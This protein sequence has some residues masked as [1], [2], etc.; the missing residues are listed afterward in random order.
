MFK[1]KIQN[2]LKSWLIFFLFAMVQNCA[3]AQEPN[4]FYST[5]EEMKAFFDKKY[6]KIEIEIIQY[7]GRGND[8]VKLP[9]NSAKRIVEFTID[10]NC[11][12]IDISKDNLWD[13]TLYSYDKCGKLK[14]IKGHNIYS[15]YSN[16][17]K[18]C[19]LT[20][21]E[22]NETQIESSGSYHQWHLIKYSYNAK[23]QVK[24]ELISEFSDSLNLLYANEF[25]YTGKIKDSMNEY[26]FEEGIKMK[27]RSTKYYYSA[28]LDSIHVYN[29]EF[30]LIDKTL[31]TYHESG[32]LKS[33]F[34]KGLGLYV[35]AYN[36]N[37]E[38]I[39]IV[40]DMANKEYLVKFFD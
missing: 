35:Y 38:L 21:R 2:R 39:S 13:T 15:K 33:V 28:H 10:G 4:I 36:A 29:P 6:S 22:A 20:S 12:V 24:R 16:R 8:K 17:Y 11:R 27:N 37:N 5:P 32:K 26:Y 1:N 40:E 14:L 30:T 31:Y 7:R 18:N 23:M 34:I 19:Q 9:G 25:A 3:F